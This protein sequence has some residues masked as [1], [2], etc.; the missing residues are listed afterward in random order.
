MLGI[1]LSGGGLGA[2]IWPLVTTHLISSYGWRNACMIIAGISLIVI[3]LAARFLRYAPEQIEQ[4]PRHRDKTN[5][6]ATGLSL[7]EAVGR[8]EFWLLGGAVGCLWL[9]GTSIMAHIVIHVIDLGI[10]NTTAAT[11]PAVIGGVGIGGRIVM[12]SFADKIGYRRA[13]VVSFAVLALIILWLLAAKELWALYLFAVIFSLSRSCA[14]LESPLA[15]Q[16]FGLA[17]LGEVV[18]GFEFIGATFC[19]FGPTMT[20]W[21]FDTTGSYQLAFLILTGVAVA[22]FI[23]SLLLKQPLAE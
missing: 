16:L 19:I 8:K 13:F 4:L 9:C 17:R 21:V 6:Q 18:G 15:A 11:I 5:E 20:G 22:G 7:R 1:V 2:I 10:P 23:I 3:S 12:G 14:I